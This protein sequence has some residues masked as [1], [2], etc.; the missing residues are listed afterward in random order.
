LVREIIKNRTLLKV[1]NSFYNVNIVSIGNPHCILFV[2]NFDFDYRSLGQKIENHEQ[3]HPDRTNVGFIQKISRTEVNFRVWERGSGETMA[4]G[5]GACAA[6]VA[7]VTNGMTERTVKVHLKGGS[8][9]IE[10][11]QEKDTLL[12]IGPATEVFTGEYEYKL[13]E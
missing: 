6:V 5:T 11:N 3:F 2:D 1:D 4:C 12:M 7:L 9:D 10:W 13:E 8:L